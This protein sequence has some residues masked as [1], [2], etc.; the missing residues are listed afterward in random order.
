V[1]KWWS[2][3]FGGVLLAAFGLC[4][5]AVFVKG[6]WLA[7]NVASFGWDVDKLFY[8]I[9]AFVTFF[10]VLTEAILVYAMWRFA[11]QPGRK[12]TYVEGNQRLEWFWTIVP[13]GIL[14]YIAF[15]QVKTWADIKYQLRM[16]K[17]NQIVQVTAQQWNWWMRYPTNV[18][19]KDKKDMVPDDLVPDDPQAWAETPASDD[20]HL[21]NE[22]HT[23]KGAN[24][25]VYLRTQDVIH[26][27]FLPNLRLKQDALPG[28]TIPIWFQVTDSNGEWDN[29]QEKWVQDSDPKK[30]WEIACAELCGARHYAMRGRLY[31]HPDRDN[32]EAWL[33]HALAEQK[34]RK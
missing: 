4:V 1:Q 30:E 33:E 23:W 7:P 28:K 26:S 12:A 25:K 17:P 32:Y 14:L 20:L 18:K 27:F 21:G 9:L 2:A 10:F 19:K 24:V 13:A 8:I 29:K 16:P 34:A 22:L 31:V 3:F 6:W 15:A 5:A 11:Y